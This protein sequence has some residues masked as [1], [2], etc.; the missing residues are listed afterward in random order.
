MRCDCL[1]LLLAMPMGAGTGY[2]RRGGLEKE[3]RKESGGKREKR[4]KER[5]RE[6]RETGEPTMKT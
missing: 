6:K 3:A 4:E 5:G 2:I 1:F